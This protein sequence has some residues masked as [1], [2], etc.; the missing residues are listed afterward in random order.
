M[1]VAGYC[2]MGKKGEQGA[3]KGEDTDQIILLLS[4]FVKLRKANISFV[5][6]V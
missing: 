6:S 3:L 2:G 4:V 1:Y 5:M